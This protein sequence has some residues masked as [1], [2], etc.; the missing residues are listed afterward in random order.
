MT[1]F[2]YLF[3]DACCFSHFP[4]IPHAVVLPALP[5]LRAPRFVLRQIDHSL[6]AIEGKRSF[7]KE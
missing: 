2:C 3:P 1:S 5:F 6:F 7:Q 4:E